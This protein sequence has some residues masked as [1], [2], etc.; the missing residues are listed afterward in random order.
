ME[1]DIAV[2]IVSWN[3]RDY[4]KQCLESIYQAACKVSF[5]VWVVDNASKDGSPE[6]VEELFPQVH[7]IQTGKNLGFAGGNNVGIEASQGRYLFLV[8]SDV[9]IEDHCFDKLC[10]FMDDNPDI[11]L[12]GPRVLN[13]DRSLQTSCMVTP[14]PWRGLSRAL[15]LDTTFPK[16]EAFGAG[17][18]EF[19]PH[20]EIRDVDVL[21][22][23]FWVARREALAK[24]GLLDEDYFMYMEDVD[25]SK[26]FRDCGWRVTFYPEVEIIHFGGGSSANAPLKYYLE[27]RRSTLFYWRKHYGFAG[28]IYIY[29]ISLLYEKLRILRAAALWLLRPAQR[30]ENAHKLQRSW[31]TLL[32]LLNIPALRLRIPRTG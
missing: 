5:E 27:D 12:S 23:C 25:W 1:P 3:A 14:T 24:T 2:V 31:Q 28:L 9:I 4:L 8:N 21:V 13:A 10:A 29:F 17:M 19:W 22:G 15:A 32:W 30:N 20:N 11:G 7:L 16:C 18:M 26:R 6:M